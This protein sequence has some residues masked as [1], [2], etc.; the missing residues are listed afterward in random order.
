MPEQLMNT[1]DVALFD[2]EIE[3]YAAATRPLLQSV[4]ILHR[5]KLISEHYWRGFATT[6]YQPV[7]SITKSVVSALIGMAL[8]DGR[9]TLAD[10]M[11]HWFPEMGFA[12]G[13]HAASV[14]IRHLLTMTA[15]FQEV[16]GR[17]A[18]D[19]PIAALLRRAPASAP[20]ETFRYVTEDV[21]LLIPVLERAVGESAIDYA[22][23]RLFMPLGIWRDISKF[24]RKRLWKTDKQGR[25]KGDRGLH[26]TTRELASFG[27]LYL[28]G[29]RWQDEQLLL[30][31]FV[32]ASTTAQVSGGYPERVKYGYLWWVSV[33]SEGRPAFFASGAG[34]QY[35]YVLPSLDLVV[36]ITSTLTNM[37][38]R[39]HRVMI[40]R[41]VTDLMNVSSSGEE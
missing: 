21:N 32:A 24:N 35:V 6:S 38:G 9:L 16:D 33:D 17:M 23:S 15:G 10:T 12:P 36:A 4:L 11:A 40:V 28:Q 20:G 34:G 31:D 14:T 1:P 7:F 2:A 13:G 18:S 37:D 19:D 27:Q 5:G 3:A 29:G 22:H 25:V 30:P 8:A 41:L 26:L 39:P